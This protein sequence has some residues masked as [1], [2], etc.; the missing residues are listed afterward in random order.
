MGRVGPGSINAPGG[1]QRPPVLIVLPL[2]EEALHAASVKQKK[3]RQSWDV[4]GVLK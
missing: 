2:L 4:G 3:C 1:G